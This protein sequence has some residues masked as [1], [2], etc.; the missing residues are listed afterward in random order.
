M[1]DYFEGNSTYLNFFNNL[2]YFKYLNVYEKSLFIY[3]TKIIYL[4]SRSLLEFSLESWNP[5]F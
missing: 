2:V 3:K 1:K 5:I 4:E